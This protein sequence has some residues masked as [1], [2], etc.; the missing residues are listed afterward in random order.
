MARKVPEW[1]GKTDDTPLPKSA[2]L[3]LWRKQEGLCGHCGRKL[4]P[5]HWTRE[6]IK[7]IWE[8]GENRESNI[9]LWCTSPCSSAKTAS[10]VAP[11]AKTDRQLARSMKYEAP[12]KKPFPGGKGSKWKR[13]YD[14]ATGRWVTVRREP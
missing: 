8:G 11:R 3:R 1:I 14:R 12:S 9:E 2:F 6:H 7:P 10:E 13:K 5:G 4:L